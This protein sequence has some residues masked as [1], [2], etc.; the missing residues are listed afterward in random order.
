MTRISPHLDVGQRTGYGEINPQ[1]ADSHH[2]QD[3]DIVVLPSRR[4]EM[5]APDGISDS[6]TPGT[7]L[8]PIHFGENHTNVRPAL[9]PLIHW[10]K[11]LNLKSAFSRTG[12]GGGL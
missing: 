10:P 5:E 1:D 2:I 9:M 6:V 12:E 3:G 4:C 8:L 11:Y 7:L